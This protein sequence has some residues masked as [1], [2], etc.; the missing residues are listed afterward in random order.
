MPKTATVVLKTPEGN[1][2][3]IS[4]VPA[5]KLRG[6]DG[7]DVTFS[8]GGSAVTQTKTI[9]LNME[10][11]NQVVSPD[12][13]Y[14]AMTQVTVTKPNTL[15]PGNIKNG[16]S[17]GGVSGTYTGL[18]PSGNADI[19]DT[20][21]VDVTD[22]AT[23]R[24]SA[25][26]RAK[27]I[28]NNIANG[29]TLLGVTGT[30]YGGTDTTDATAESFDIYQ[31]RTAYVDGS[32][33]TGILSVKGLIRNGD[34]LTTLYFSGDNSAVIAAAEAGSLSED[35]SVTILRCGQADGS[36]RLEIISD[37]TVSNN[38]YAVDT[39]LKIYQSGSIVKTMHL[40]NSEC[41]G[42]LDIS[43]YTLPTA[44][45]VLE[46][47]QSIVSKEPLKTGIDSLSEKYLNNGDRITD[48]YFN[49]DNASLN[50]SLNV[51][52]ASLSY[53]QTDQNT[54][55]DYE[56]LGLNYLCA[57]DL[58]SVGLGNGYAIYWG[59]DLTLIYS[60]IAF[61]ASAYISGFKV[62]TPGWQVE[63]VHLTASGNNGVVV[64]AGSFNPWLWNIRHLLIS[65]EAFGAGKP[66]YVEGSGSTAA[67]IPTPH[68]ISEIAN[69]IS[70]LKAEKLCCLS[71]DVSPLQMGI[72]DVALFFYDYNSTTKK[73]R[74]SGYAI[75]LNGG[76][77]AVAELTYDD[78]NNTLTLTGANMGG[79]DISSYIPSMSWKI[80]VLH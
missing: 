32:K 37:I 45:Y 50:S 1:D 30:H 36:N 29:V 9:S 55:L 75:D 59:Y 33:I 24:I 34:T 74:F 41:V 8:I 79:T 56:Y 80:S 77:Y 76:T 62:T 15:I 13:G 21:E 39:V 25:T 65:P 49:T 66:W 17:I 22:K 31:G 19:S 48:L 40:N 12:N 47:A 60:T 11:G 35:T 27:I 28:P 43:S 42:V 61:D 68:D 16:V 72:S 51:F 23:A 20:S 5:V 67:N 70:L 10:N 57:G 7:N 18:V 38:T 2:I 6:A 26:E 54:G 63:K 64:N 44:S 71:V 58:S 53:N 4:N 52:L 69:D 73:M 14:N 78:V 46:V 3:T